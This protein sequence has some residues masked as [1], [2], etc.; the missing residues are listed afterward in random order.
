MTLEKNKFSDAT[1]RRG[2]RSTDLEKKNFSIVFD[3]GLSFVIE[4]AVLRVKT[5]PKCLPAGLS[6]QVF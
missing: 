6:F 4:N 5:T 1:S 2:A 3:C